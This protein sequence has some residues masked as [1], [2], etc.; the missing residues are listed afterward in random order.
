MLLQQILPASAYG[1]IDALEGKLLRYGFA[2]ADA[3]AGDDGDFTVQ[4]EIHVL[5]QFL[6]VAK[7]PFQAS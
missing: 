7:A 4:V 3:P 1:D 2:D 5:L 6:I